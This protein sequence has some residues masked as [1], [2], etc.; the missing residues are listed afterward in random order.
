MKTCLIPVIA[1][2][3][4]LLPS[5][6]SI[7]E[8]RLTDP[9]IAHVAYTAGVIDVENAEQALSKSKNKDVIEFAN[10]MKKD[11]E[12]V[13]KQALALV[14]KLKLQPEENAV[15]E[16][17]TKASETK[18]GELGK[19]EG[20]RFDSAYV[21]NEIAY[22]RQVNGALQETLIPGAKNEELK[23]LLET[24]LKLFQGHEQHAEHIAAG[25]K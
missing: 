16:A 8:D 22:H 17:L 15:S 4:M 23:T 12:A 21:E 5:A 24:G 20:S 19:L 13:N 6:M 18:R 2:A 9:Q 11:H 1:S 7:A 3:F 14:K 10:L 25:L